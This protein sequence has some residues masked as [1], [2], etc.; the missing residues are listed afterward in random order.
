MVRRHDDWRRSTFDS[1]ASRVISQLYQQRVGLLSRRFTVCIV[2]D[3]LSESLPRL[4]IRVSLR[5][6][7]SLTR[8]FALARALNSQDEREGLREKR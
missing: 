7:D 6:A 2:P 5:M 1:K 8:S 3:G 4:A